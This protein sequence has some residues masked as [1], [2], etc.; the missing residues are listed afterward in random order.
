MSETHQH[1]FLGDDVFGQE[2]SDAQ[3]AGLLNWLGEPSKRVVDLG[4]GSGRIVVPLAVA[5]HEVVGVD[6]DQKSIDLCCDALQAQKVAAE[7]VCDDFRNPVAEVTGRVD[8]FVCLGN[9]FMLLVDPLEAVKLL[10]QWGQQL[11]PGGA[12]I[13]DDIPQDLLGELTEGR[14]QD[15]LSEDGQLQMAWAHGD[16]VF[17][18]RSGDQIEVDHEGILVGEPCFRLW[19][20]GALDLVASQAGL[21]PPQWLSDA[22]LLVLG[23]KN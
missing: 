14:W 3:I 18:V 6:S 21:A 15:G 5:G 4:C 9:T 2:R 13:I 16:L 8:A 12:I 1:W 11:A 19:T 10:S 7:I 20:M 22:G 23:A 17:A